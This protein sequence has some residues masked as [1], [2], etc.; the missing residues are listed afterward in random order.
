MVDF[1]VWGGLLGGVPTPVGGGTGVWG[2][3]NAS[4]EATD[5]MEA[6]AASSPKP[7]LRLRDGGDPGAVGLSWASADTLVWVANDGPKTLSRLSN[8]GGCDG[9]ETGSGTLCGGPLGERGDGNGE[10]GCCKRDE[11]EALASI[12]N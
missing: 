12:S 5:L 2:G 4:L 1:V 7:V 11:A 8:V 3:V 9:G 6:D 10:G